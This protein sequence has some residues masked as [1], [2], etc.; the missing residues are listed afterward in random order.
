MTL[1]YPV[2]TND[3]TINVI[4]TSIG[5]VSG[6]FE[7]LLPWKFNPNIVCRGASKTALSDSFVGTTQSCANQET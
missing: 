1:Y 4:I 6:S 3:K 7:I 2:L 5:G